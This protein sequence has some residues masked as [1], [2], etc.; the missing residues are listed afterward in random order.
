MKPKKYFQDVY[1]AVKYCITTN[2]LAFITENEV[3]CLGEIINLSKTLHLEF[4][5]QEDV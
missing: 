3:E 5:T 1:Q 2:K 4:K